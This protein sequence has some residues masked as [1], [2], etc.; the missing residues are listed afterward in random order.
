MVLYLWNYWISFL[1]F[2]AQ[3]SEWNVAFIL[4]V[5]GLVR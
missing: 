2:R 1:S 5:D 4:L 3:Y